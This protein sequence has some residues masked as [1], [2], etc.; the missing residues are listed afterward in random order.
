MSESR[1]SLLLVTNNGKGRRKKKQKSPEPLTALEQ[2]CRGIDL[3]LQIAVIAPL[4]REAILNLLHL[5]RIG[6]TIGIGFGIPDDK[7]H[8]HLRHLFCA[9]GP[10][11]INTVESLLLAGF[12]RTGRRRSLDV[13]FKNR[14][15]ACT[16][17]GRIR[18]RKRSFRGEWD[19]MQPGRRS[20]SAGYASK[21]M[22]LQEA[23]AGNVEHLGRW[24]ARENRSLRAK[25][26]D[27]R[28]REK[29]EKK[30]KKKE[31]HTSWLRPRAFR[32]R[33]AHRCVDTVRARA[34][35]EWIA[36]KVPYRVSRR[37]RSIPQLRYPPPWYLLLTH[38]IEW[39]V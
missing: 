29:E 19:T 28:R 10:R 33:D 31:T 22:L 30:E 16:C 8:R 25:K 2:S 5:A 9:N 1:D 15:R 24:A 12:R 18:V 36:G 14:F 11:G 4:A 23:R 3:H 7:A 21:S 13:T 37:R 6:I 35:G 38:Y 32:G 17:P 27:E 34:Y 20:P 39:H 26:A